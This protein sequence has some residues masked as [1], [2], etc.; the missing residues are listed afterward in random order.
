MTMAKSAIQNPKSAIEVAEQEQLEQCRA[1]LLPL[2]RISPQ[3]DRVAVHKND[4][5]TTT[6]PS[7]FTGRYTVCRCKRT[8]TITAADIDAAV[9]ALLPAATLAA[10]QQALRPLAQLPVD[11][12]V[13]E[14]EAPI[15]VFPGSDGNLVPIT[16]A[17]IERAQALVDGGSR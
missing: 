10:G 2:A 1:A 14:P 6:P 13:E 15:F 17:M 9:N 16:N 5:G 12:R 11:L 3:G 8:R 4:D 7:A